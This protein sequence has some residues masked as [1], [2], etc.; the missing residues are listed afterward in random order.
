MTPILFDYDKANIR[1]DQET[2]L[3][4]IAAWLK[5]ALGESFT[6]EGHADER[7]GQEYNIALGDERAAATKKFLV[8][9]GIAESRMQTVSFGEERPA[10][11]AETE[12]C[13]QMNRRAAFQRTR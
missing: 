12:D 7:G 1:A 6:I 4:T 10:C 9:Q 13:W 2:R 5:Q 8:A 3:R 11:R